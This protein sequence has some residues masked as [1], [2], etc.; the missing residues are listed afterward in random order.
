MLFSPRGTKDAQ[1]STPNKR[2]ITGTTDYITFTCFYSNHGNKTCSEDHLSPKPTDT[3]VS[4]SQTTN[5]VP[6]SVMQ[7]SQH[8][9]VN[10]H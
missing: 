7:S 6:E 5:I 4:K 2:S 9:H 8:G 1:H 3:N 10:T